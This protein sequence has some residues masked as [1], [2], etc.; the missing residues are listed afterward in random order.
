MEK[1]KK[2]RDEENRDYTVTVSYGEMK[3]EDCMKK[4][5]R[6]VTRNSFRDP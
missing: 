4:V 6:I 5:I 1:V 2:K 3:L